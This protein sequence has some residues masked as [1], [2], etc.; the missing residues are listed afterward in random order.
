MGMPAGALNPRP[1][2]LRPSADKGPFLPLPRPRGPFRRYQYVRGS[3]PFRVG[4]GRLVCA[5]VVKA[6]PKLHP[7]RALKVYGT[8]LA[9]SGRLL[10]MMAVFWVLLCWW[11]GVGGFGWVW[12]FYLF[13]GII[14]FWIKR[15]TGPYALL[16]HVHFWTKSASEPHTRL[17]QCGSG[18]MIHVFFVGPEPQWSRSVCGP[19]VH[20]VQ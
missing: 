8:D 17:D 19:E 15:A 6:S 7:K 1:G 5:S 14:G 20:V 2:S 16:D 13:V 11:L 4:C 12:R 10:L 9:N 18:P 3:G